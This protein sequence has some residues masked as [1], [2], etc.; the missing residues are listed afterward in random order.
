[1]NKQEKKI[2]SARLDEETRAVLQIYGTFL[3]IAIGGSID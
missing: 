2:V 1:L 3:G